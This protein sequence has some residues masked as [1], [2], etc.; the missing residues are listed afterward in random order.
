MA[1]VEALQ[2]V[3]DVFGSI[4][5]DPAIHRT[6]AMRHRSPRGRAFLLPG[7]RERIANETPVRLSD[8]ELGPMILEQTVPARVAKR[9]S[10][11]PVG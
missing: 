10:K 9:F 3:E 1:Q 8:G 11:W 6:E 4:S 2:T 7:F 5:R